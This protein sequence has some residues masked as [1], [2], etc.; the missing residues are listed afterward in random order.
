MKDIPQHLCQCNCWR[1]ESIRGSRWQVEPTREARSNFIFTILEAKQQKWWTFFCNRAC[2]INFNKLMKKKCLRK[3]W[4]QQSMV[5]ITPSESQL[6]SILL[7]WFCIIYKIRYIKMIYQSAITEV[8]Q[9]ASILISIP[10]G[11]WP[12]KTIKILYHH[13]AGFPLM[14]ILKDKTRRRWFITN[15]PVVS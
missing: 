2:D 4:N 1:P 14:I 3:Q 13:W 5:R 7:P 12:L 8:Y 15:I 10:N 9:S 11:I 6:Q